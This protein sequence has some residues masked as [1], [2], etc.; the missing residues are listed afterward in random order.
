MLFGVIK[1]VMQKNNFA[2]FKEF[3]DFFLNEI[4][5]F[6]S[7]AVIDI[8]T[9][10]IVPVANNVYGASGE[11]M[12]GSTYGEVIFLVTVNSISKQVEFYKE[13]EFEWYF[14]N[15]QDSLHAVY[16]VEKKVLTKFES[17]KFIASLF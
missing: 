4:S 6:Y 12:N 17:E 11:Q 10:N 5:N 9:A 13:C 2:S 3:C 7:A 16:D 8:Y 1:Y 14:G 15:P